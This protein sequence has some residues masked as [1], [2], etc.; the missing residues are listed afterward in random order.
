MMSLVFLCMR[1]GVVITTRFHRSQFTTLAVLILNIMLCNVKK[2]I[3][4]I[5]L[6]IPTG[7]NELLCPS[8]NGSNFCSS[9]RGSVACGI[10]LH[11]KRSRATKNGREE[12]EFSSDKQYRITI[13]LLSQCKY[14]G[15]YYCTNNNMM[16]VISFVR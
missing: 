12:M 9:G 8:G 5:S 16:Y 1:S 13:I 4:W 10:Y 2:V 7:R 3:I 15:I 11:Q 14:C 6:F